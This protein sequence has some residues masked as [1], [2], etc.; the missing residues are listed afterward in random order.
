MLA[1]PKR[2]PRIKAIFHGRK[3]YYSGKPCGRGHNSPRFTSSRICV[4]C[5]R[6]HKDRTGLLTWA[7]RR[8]RRDLGWALDTLH[9]DGAHVN[10]G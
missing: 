6:E 8:L 1:K 10:D 3:T 2:S 4:E 7:M 5:D 9:G